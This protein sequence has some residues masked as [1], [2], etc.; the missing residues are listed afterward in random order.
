M[1][2]RT[3]DLAVML[4]TDT[5]MAEAIGEA[6]L[7]HRRLPHPVLNQIEDQYPREIAR[8]RFNA[9][10]AARG[11]EAP[12]PSVVATQFREEL[13]ALFRAQGRLIEPYTILV[14]PP[15]RD[16]PNW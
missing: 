1:R 9:M 4:G 16:R 3:L 5:G 2:Q 15:A 6:I 12:E 7:A 10:W 13:A 14:G 11:T 8:A